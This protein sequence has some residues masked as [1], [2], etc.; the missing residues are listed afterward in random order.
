[1]DNPNM[2]KFKAM[3]MDVQVEI[4]EKSAQ[5]VL[6]VREEIRAAKTREA[7]RRGLLLLEGAQRVI[8]Q[9]QNYLDLIEMSRIPVDYPIKIRGEPS[10]LESIQLEEIIGVENP[11]VPPPQ[12]ISPGGIST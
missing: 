12:I 3:S 2:T 4:I 6:R 1:M 11:E 10:G 7:Q 9:L 8:D 5:E